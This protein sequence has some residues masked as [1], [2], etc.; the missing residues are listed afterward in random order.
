MIRGFALR[1]ALRDLR[2]AGRRLTLFVLSISVGVAAIVAVGGFRSNL[3]TGLR[4]QGRI[5]LGA[6]LE[7][8]SRFPFPREVIAVLDSVAGSDEGAWAEVT[9]VP[10]MVSATSTGRSALL[11]MSVR[12][13]HARMIGTWM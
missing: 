1:M 8:Q 7:L 12:M 10:T 11:A 5:L 2:S 6:D 4:D 9:T 13:K 3:L